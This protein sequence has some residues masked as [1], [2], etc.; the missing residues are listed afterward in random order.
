MA[1][2]RPDGFALATDVAE[3]LVRSGVPF[4]EAH[5]LAGDCV[6]TCEE[7]GIDLPDLSDADLAAISPALTPAVRE[8]LT[9][10]GVAAVPVRVRRHR[11]GPGPR[12]ARATCAPVVA[13]GLAW[14]AG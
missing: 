3:W 7:R 8:V 12:A 5:E 6:R 4:R 9:V 14:A 13:A 11:P 2:A 1:A 10:A